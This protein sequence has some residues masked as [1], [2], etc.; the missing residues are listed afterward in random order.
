VA[1]K[2]LFDHLRQTAREPA[3]GG[4]VKGSVEAGLADAAVKLQQTYT[5]AYVTHAAIEPRSALAEWNG[6]DLTVWAATQSPFGVR[7]RLAQE[8][9]LPE[10]RVR[11]LAVD[12]GIGYGGKTWNQAAL[13]AARL[14]KVAGKPVRV[15]WTR[16]EEMTRNYFRPAGIIDIRSGARADG[17]LTVWEYRNFSSGPAALATPYEVP[18]QLVEFRPCDSP[19]PQGA[20]RALAAPGNFFARETHMDELA[21]ALKVD[22]L[23]FRLKNVTEPRLRA[24]LEAAAKGFGWGAKPA[25]GRGFGLACGTDKGG[26]VATCAEISVDRL[27]A[28]AASAEHAK[29]V[30]AARQVKVERI[31]TA[32]ECGAI[33]NPLQLR[34]QIEGGAAFAL[35]AALFEAIEFEEGRVLNPN[36]LTY[37]LPRFSDLPQ[38]EAILLDRKDLPSAGAGETP[39]CA[40]GP[41]LGNAIFHATG[42]RLRSLPLVPNGL[43][44]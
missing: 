25:E 35:G 43:P 15:A 23:A 33:I 6:D 7:S 5:L 37:R 16:E 28:S 4:Q 22:P 32:F 30:D 42:V 2:D 31:V 14:A 27:R 38:I 10:N 40:I 8:L 36:F 3:R 41:A 20:Y 9:G 24:V 17:T 34:N 1:Q 12:T 26:W 29:P 19:W 11:V 39:T 13:E 44:A 18:N 21:D